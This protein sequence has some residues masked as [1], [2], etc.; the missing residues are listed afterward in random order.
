M[1]MARVPLDVYGPEPLATALQD[2][3]WVSDV[4]VAHEAVVEHFSRQAGATV[5]P[6]KLFTMFSTTA[7]A[8]EEMRSRRA[9]IDRV[10]R[11]VGGCEE[12]GVRITR[13][14]PARP[15]GAAA[16][17][18]RGRSAAPP[19]SGVAF[20]AAKKQA[21]DDAR[22]SERAA[23]A[24][25]HAAFEALSEI[26]RDAR[27]RDDVPQGAASPPVLDAAFLVPNGRRARF[28]AAARR[29]AAA[30]AKAGARLTVTG[31][32]PAY[33]FVQNESS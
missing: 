8:V 32:W 23:A 4:A 18:P 19:A 26:A 5:I 15:R 30:T 29:L 31:P 14:A 27:R 12:W 10:I 6:M 21:R 7:R 25:A 20:L 1:V 24:A 13:S 28:R 9:A 3:R 33:N 22:E 11:R 16:G 2:L 17:A